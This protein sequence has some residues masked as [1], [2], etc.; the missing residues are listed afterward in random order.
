[1][2]GRRLPLGGGP[3][4]R[5][6]SDADQPNPTSA[7]ESSPSERAARS[8]ATMSTD[9]SPQ[10]KPENSNETPTN[11]TV[12]TSLR[13]STRNRGDS[14]NNTPETGTAESPAAMDISPAEGKSLSPKAILGKMSPKTRSEDS[15][16]RTAS[17]RRSAG[18]GN[19]E[20]SPDTASSPEGTSETPQN[21]NTTRDSKEIDTSFEDRSLVA[22]DENG[23]EISV[24]V[25]F[26]GSH[27]PYTPPPEGTPDSFKQTTGTTL[28]YDGNLYYC[29]VCHGF[30]DV[31]CCDGCPRVYHHDCI[32]LEDPS[33]R[34]LDNDEDPWFCPECLKKDK[35]A[36][37]SRASQ[38]AAKGDRRPTSNNRCVDCLHD[39]EGVPVEPCSECGNYCHHPSCIGEA[40]MID[41]PVL[42]ATCRAVEDLTREEDDIHESTE[43]S[44]ASEEAESKSRRKRSR[45]D[46]MAMDKKNGEKKKKKRKKQKQDLD[47]SKHDR[48]PSERELEEDALLQQ[49]RVP[50][51]VQAIPGFYFY[52]A[53]NRWKI[54]R[55]LARKHR[56]FNRLPKGSER[57]ELVTKEAAIW[58]VKLRPTDHRRYMTMSMRDFEARIIEW[59]EEKN[60][61]DMLSGGSEYEDAMI[62]EPVEESLAFED[63]E[64]VVER[65]EKRFHTTSVG[66]KPFKPEADHSYNRVLLD[67]LH[68]MRFHP[69]P[70]VGINRPDN[71]KA[72]DEKITVPY[73][74]VHGPVSTSVGDECLG[75]SRGWRHYCPVLKHQIPAI[76]HRA[77]LQPPLSSLMATRVGLGLRPRLERTEDG[78]GEELSPDDLDVPVFSVRMSVEEEELRNLPVVPSSS[79]NNV[80]DRVDEI[81]HVIDETTAMRV[82]EPQ[83]P[84]VADRGQTSMPS[85][86]RSLPLQR[87]REETSEASFGQNTGWYRCGRC[88]TVSE[89]E[90]GCIQCRR[91][92][93]VIN[94]TKKSSHGS[95]HGASKN[96]SKG[97]K[98][99]TV[100]LGRV[101]MKEFSGDQPSEGN[102]AVSDFILKQRWTPM[103]VLPPPHKGIAPSASISHPRQENEEE[104]EEEEEEQ[105]LMSVS[106]EDRTKEFVSLENENSVAS[107]ED[108][109]KEDEDSKADRTRTRHRPTRLLVSSSSTKDYNGSDRIRQLK[110][111]QKE[112]EL[113]SRSLAIA[114]YALYLAVIR[115]DPQKLF[116]RSPTD[117]D[118]LESLQIP[119]DFQTIRDNILAKQYA[120][121]DDLLADV[122]LLCDN[123]LGFYPPHSVQY[124]TATEVK[125][126]L[127]SAGLKAKEWLSTIN[128]HYVQYLADKAE[129]QKVNDVGDD[130]SDSSSEDDPFG[131]LRARWPE[132][133]EMLENGESL[134][135]HVEADFRRTKENE[136]A[137]YATLAIPRAAAAA[138]ESLAPYAYSSG[139]HGVVIRR[140]HVEDEELRSMI[141]KKVARLNDPVQLSQVSNWREESVIRLLRSVQS[142]R[143][144]RRTI[145]ENGCARCV[146]FDDSSD[147]ILDEEAY[148]PEKKRKRGE[149]ENGR[150]DPSR[151]YLTTGLGSAKTCQGIFQRAEK[152]EESFE[153][154][155]DA[156]VSVRGSKIHGM[157][158]FADQPFKKGSV[159]AEYVGEYIGAEEVERREKKYR[160]ERRPDFIF[161]VNEKLGIDATMKGSPARFIN[162][163]CEPNC[164]KKIIPGKAQHE[165]LQRVLIIAQRNIDIN[166]EITFDYRIP[167]EVDLNARVP[168][169]CQ[170]DS[171]R[172][173]MVG[174]VLLCFPSFY[175]LKYPWFPNAFL[176]LHRI[177]ICPKLVRTIGLYWSTSVGPIC[178]TGFVD[179]AAPSREMKFELR[180]KLK[181]LLCQEC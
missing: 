54:E 133:V 104:E 131:N 103:A 179:Y 69:S 67:L 60:L 176:L 37:T 38:R 157:G 180:A 62:T 168:C 110:R 178:V 22:M 77:K 49:M 94:L 96:D 147:L 88:R 170:A 142:R 113:K 40:G 1:M 65:H 135:R 102:M 23:R 16:R 90:M 99:H 128:G 13:R 139:E 42:C 124:K 85:L 48:V 98:V 138:A 61:K 175:H 146:K 45:G 107:L 18:V 20:T 152:A 116:A 47:S 84:V 125:S 56:Y 52:L 106:V 89:S 15:T 64:R 17:R 30:G 6:A 86:A 21:M 153:T 169:N 136:L 158:L 25:I 159:V 119:M 31:V 63:E 82:P 177:G 26:N 172:G 160:E 9:A 71:S 141:D 3:S 112:E 95:D 122:R 150:V 5:S 123:A 70:M 121:T 35:Q 148:N 165:D 164:Y 93:L 27:F 154:V 7:V 83:K 171:C 46:S 58:W 79:L 14:A 28:G 73:F 156:C 167:F 140:D 126:I 39:I 43:R 36:S 59:K 57:N 163:S 34:S 76:E 144:E 155:K 137:Y 10:E 68:D 97:L 114:C 127:S 32:P 4:R 55:I 66:S 100:M 166:E 181:A 130:Q 143:L 78:N 173:F 129:R 19:E 50:G 53:E 74:E 115:R 105:D 72:T 41:D 51:P 24:R 108:T 117:K 33:R 134:K 151:L 81:V 132:A 161:R 118:F 120:A 109:G 8:S 87:S 149:D 174:L 29:F 12:E 2:K 91:A 145:P 11:P 75:C 92:Q 44:L 101:Q 111:Q 80:P 162:H